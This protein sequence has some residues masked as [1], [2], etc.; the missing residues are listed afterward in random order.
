MSPCHSERQRKAL[1]SSQR[2]RL[3]VI[4]RNTLVFK[5]PFQFPPHRENVFSSMVR[6]G[7]AVP[8]SF[9]FP[10]HR[11]N[12]F[13]AWIAGDPIDWNY[14]QFPPH[15][16]NVFSMGLHELGYEEAGSFS[17]L[18][19]GKM[20]SARR[21]V[22]GNRGPISFSSLLIGKMFSARARIGMLRSS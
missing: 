6:A 21:Y 17:S 18:L 5:L 22:F 1:F 2:K 14:F 8:T 12:V 10:P 16:E 3:V 4:E 20:F 11:E 7:T 13:S 15:R 9:Q 19:I